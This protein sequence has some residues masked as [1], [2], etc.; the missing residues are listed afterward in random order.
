MQ[1]AMEFALLIQLLW[2]PTQKVVTPQDFQATLGQFKVFLALFFSTDF[3]CQE[4]KNGAY[5]LN[6]LEK[7][8]ALS[9]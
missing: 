7:S 9:I 1:V 5:V 3:S 2:L 6:I 8:G 4:R